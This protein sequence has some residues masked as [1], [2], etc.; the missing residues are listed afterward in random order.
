MQLAETLMGARRIK[1]ELYALLVLVVWL[2]GSIE[3]QT[4]TN[5]TDADDGQGGW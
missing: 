4:L 1:Y 2:F 3:R 5:E